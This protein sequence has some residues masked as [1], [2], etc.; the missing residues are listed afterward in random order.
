MS[1]SETGLQAGGVSRRGAIGLMA[2]ATAGAA[3]VPGGALASTL[4][5]GAAK[6]HSIDAQYA[7]PGGRIVEG[8]FARPSGKTSLDVL[9]VMHGEAGY[10]DA[11]QQTAA[12]Y[13]AKGYLAIA[14]D[15]KASF[16]KK[17][18]NDRAALISEARKMVPAFAKMTHANGRVTLVEA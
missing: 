6:I 12:R 18:G 14:L 3:G 13:A 8:Y 16:G 9:L 10:G 1:T 15:L 11:A 4:L 7:L 2:A 17:V 5:P